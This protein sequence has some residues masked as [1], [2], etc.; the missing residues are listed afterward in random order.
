M[1]DASIRDVV[2]S[3][4]DRDKTTVLLNAIGRLPMHAEYV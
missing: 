2:E 3:L 4:S 1:L